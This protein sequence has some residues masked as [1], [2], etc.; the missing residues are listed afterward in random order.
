MLVRW[1]IAD[2]R[3]LDPVWLYGILGLTWTFHLAFTFWMLKRE[4]SD[5]TQNGRTFSFPVIAA[6]NLLIMSA[7]IIIASPTATFR[8]FFVSFWWNT[9]TFI[10]RIAETSSEMYAWIFGV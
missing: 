4:Q 2:Q 5:V 3:P 10:S 1:I 7:M 6:A 9:Q 8:N